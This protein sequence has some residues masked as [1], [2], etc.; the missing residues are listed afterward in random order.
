MNSLT[1]H[2][3][4]AKDAECFEVNTE[5]GKKTLVSFIVSD[6]GMPGSSGSSFTIEVHFMKDVA[7]TLQPHLV[8]GKEVFI[9]G[10]LCKKDYET[11]EGVR[12]TKFYYSAHSVELGNRTLKQQ[13]AAA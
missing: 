1:M 8:K 7:K 4:I 2:G 9:N 5:Y 3:V 6:F 12:K 11:T 10:F 13:E